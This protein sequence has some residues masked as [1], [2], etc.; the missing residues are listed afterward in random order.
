MAAALDLSI[1][2]L[3]VSTDVTTLAG[4]LWQ[5]PEQWKA[6]NSG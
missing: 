2:Q 6:I 4:L 1:L 3:D 5:Q